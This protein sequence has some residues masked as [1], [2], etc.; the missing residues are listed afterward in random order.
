[1]SA[2]P[3]PE[4]RLPAAPVHTQPLTADEYAAISIIIPAYNEESGIGHTLALLCEHALLRQAE[5]IVVNDGST[6]CTAD[7]VRSF[8]QVK[9]VEHPFNR[10]YGSAICSGVRASRGK[11]LLWFDGDGQH[12]VED[13][14]ALADRLILK[15]LDYCIGVRGQDSFQEANRKLGKWLL[16]QVVVFAAGNQVPDFN[17]GLRG[18]KREVL[19]QYL[20]LLPKRF[21]ASTLTTLLMVEG[22]HYG[23]TVPI[24]VNQ[25]F[26]KSTVRQLN[27]GL[28]T[29]NIIL[30]IVLL[31][32][33][34]KFFGIL[35]GLFIL[36]GSVYGVT[37]AFITGQGIPVLASLLIMLGVQS[38][39]FGL[40]GDQ[41]SALRREKFN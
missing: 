3:I 19:V 38:F 8:P 12:R 30:H 25:R 26:G 11:Y 5:V 31:F 40:L 18:F 32:K 24:V 1:M 6:D 36:I 28:N 23:E 34:L 27:D 41:V 17:S 2:S 15:Q 33:P 4:I 16:R 22:I 13:L 20:H 10:G 14:I 9:L 7:V 29:I 21:G 35:G 37:K 39:F